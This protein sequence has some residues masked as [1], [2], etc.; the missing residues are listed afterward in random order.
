MDSRLAMKIEGLDGTGTARASLTNV[1][2]SSLTEIYKHF[3]FEAQ[4]RRRFRIVIVCIVNQNGVLPQH[5][6]SKLCATAA[7]I[8]STQDSALLQW[9]ELHLTVMNQCVYIGSGK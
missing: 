9:N 4:T 1:L 2:Y 7:H 8:F 3:R 5:D 6:T